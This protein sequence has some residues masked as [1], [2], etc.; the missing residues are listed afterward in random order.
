TAPPATSPAGGS[1]LTADEFRQ[2]ADAICVR[3]DAQLEALPEP[4]SNADIPAYFRQAVGIYRSQLGEL[5]GLTP[6]PELQPDYSAA[7]GILQQIVSLAGN[8]EQRISAGEDALAVVQAA[9]PELDALNAQA[10]ARAEAL[11]LTECGSD[12]E[13]TG[14]T[15]S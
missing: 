8:V 12:D 9:T 3:Y 14:T 7:L 5:Q 2:A 13:E 4:E 11:G 1:T 15:T 6:P 10:D